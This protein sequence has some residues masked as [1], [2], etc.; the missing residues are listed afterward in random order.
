MNSTE[1]SALTILILAAVVLVAVVSNRLSER[2]RVPAPFLF[3]VGAAAV[4]DIV[5]GVG[6]KVP[7]GLVEQV[8]TVA[9]I[10]V[11][12]DGGLGI[13]WRRFR[14]AA[15]P[16]VT[17]GVAGTILTTGAVTLLAHYAC[18]LSWRTALLLGAALA[19]TDPAVVFSVLGR[20]EITG[21]TG[22][23]LEGESGAND[24]V[25]IAL[26]VALLGAGGSA[27]TQV[28][29][30]LTTFAE[31]MVVGVAVGAA[32]GFALVWFIRKVPLPGAGLHPVRA[33]AGAGVIYGAATV[34]HGSGF[35]AVLVA[36]VLIGDE[37]V[38]YRL[39]IRQVCSALASLAEIVVFVALG[40]T[41][42]L[43]ALGTDNAWLIGLVLAVLLAFV[44]R[45][46]LL[47]PLLLPV[48][49]RRGERAFVLWA[50][51]K[52]AVPILLGAFAITAGVPGSRRIYEIIF[53]VVAFSV[54]VQGGTVGLAARRFGV[55]METTT[56]TPWTFGVRLPHEPLGTRHYTIRPGDDADGTTVGD[57]VSNSDLWIS[58]VLRNGHLLS[59]TS[60]TVLHAGDELLLIGDGTT[61]G[62]AGEAENPGGSEG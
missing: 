29:H 21:R 9:L 52:G 28:G 20:R 7:I 10:V 39:E 55:P 53:V 12:F 59:I 42:G 40:L 1:S 15:V 56:P 32:G 45:P 23:I 22:T 4:S 13:G 44:V 54:L 47:G 37:S 41:I 17:L 18:D 49:M 38:P 51:L 62:E 35:L 19:P 34:A 48:R 25:G 46:L 14:A 8:V 6:G 26:M 27:G 60:D 16:V 11:L 3:L 36:G 43:R 33:L 30:I 5:P 50:G 61:T 24:P 57:I 2:I 31:Q 58:T